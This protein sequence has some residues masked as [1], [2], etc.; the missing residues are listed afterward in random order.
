MQYPDSRSDIRKLRARLAALA[1]PCVLGA[2]AAPAGA[3]PA[4]RSVAE[5]LR[6]AHVQ[7][8]APSRTRT[9]LGGGMLRVLL[10]GMANVGGLFGRGGINASRSGGISAAAYQPR[11]GQGGAFIKVSWGR[12]SSVNS[13]DVLG[14]VIWRGSPVSPVQVIGGLDG[15]TTHTFVDSEAVRNVTAYNGAPSSTDAG[16]RT[17]LTNVPGVI[18][19]EQ[20]VYQVA[21]AYTNNLEDRTGLP[22]DTDATNPDRGQPFM[23]PLSLG[24][25]YVTAIGLP[26]ITAV[27]G[28]SPSEGQQ[29]DLKALQLEWQ[30]APGANQYIIWVSTDPTFRGSS[31]TIFSGGN[32]IPVNL[33]GPGSMT[34]TIN[35]NKP[36]L[37][38][39]RR[40]YVAVGARNSG[41]P[42]PQPYGAIFGA[43][44][45]VRNEN[46][47]PPPPGSQRAAARR[48]AHRK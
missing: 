8:V 44:I 21:C 23:S 27:N 15:D 17:S 37:R 33:G 9:L 10:A 19:G 48:K 28:V 25:R 16:T 1:A 11:V 20:Y 12:G 2:L 18:P 29:V 35:A 39:H 41:D 22:S 30:Q 40:L 47:P 38:K 3:A 32:S 5:P 26:T 42:K 24:S 13:S 34:R 43:P 4:P 45:S 6:T 31:R 7:Q 14:Y 36:G 46:A